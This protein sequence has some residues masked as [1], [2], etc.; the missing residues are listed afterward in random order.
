MIL[1]LGHRD[2][3][4]YGFGG[5]SSFRSGG[6]GGGGMGMGG[7]FGGGRGGGRGMG[8]MGRGGRGGRGGMRGGRGGGG[9]GDSGYVSKTGHSVHM[10][11][12]PY[13]ATEDDILQVCCVLCLR[14]SFNRIGMCFALSTMFVFNFCMVH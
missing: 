12:L 10:R 6:Y 11:G 3:D 9:G 5:G 2:D 8:G 13:S 4:D 14:T 7:G 1:L